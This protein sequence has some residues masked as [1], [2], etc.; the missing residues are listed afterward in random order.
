MV[1]EYFLTI[2]QLSWRFGSKKKQRYT[3]KEHYKKNCWHATTK[4]VTRLKSRTKCVYYLIVVKN[5]IFPK[6]V[7]AIWT[8][9]CVCEYI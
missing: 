2:S 8:R 4:V 7:F 1:K 9:V 3:H 5:I 6:I